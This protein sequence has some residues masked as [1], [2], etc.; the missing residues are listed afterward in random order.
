MIPGVFCDH[1]KSGRQTEVH[2]CP[3]MDWTVYLPQH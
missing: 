2:R 3:M 1:K